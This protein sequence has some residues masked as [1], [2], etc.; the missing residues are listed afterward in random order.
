MIATGGSEF[1]TLAQPIFVNGK[2]VRE[3]WANGHMVYPEVGRDDFVKVRGVLAISKSF[4]RPQVGALFKDTVTGY[5]IEGSSTYMPEWNSY[6]AV[7]VVFVAIYK[8]RGSNI[9]I[10]DDWLPLTTTRYQGGYYTSRLNPLAP[11]GE[12]DSSG[13]ID[14]TYGKRIA[15]KFNLEDFR[16]QVMYDGIPIPPLFVEESKGGGWIFDSPDAY[17]RADTVPDM[18]NVL[19][20]TLWNMQTFT[21]LGS[22][23]NPMNPKASLRIS[24]HE[25]GGIV[26][27]MSGLTVPATKYYYG[28]SYFYDGYYSLR[29]TEKV[30]LEISPIPSIGNLQVPITEILYQG[31]ES[32]APDWAKTIT[33]S[34]LNA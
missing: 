25:S 33:D 9:E 7:K 12:D 8:Y 24:Q 16:C 11:G 26:L 17:T 30:T 20:A 13:A 22:Y 3:V 10:V 4:T 29:K 23:P 1:R 2:K 31:M 27:A 15:S 19:E 28:G 5:L 6:F 32:D 18:P 21:G 34:D 14:K